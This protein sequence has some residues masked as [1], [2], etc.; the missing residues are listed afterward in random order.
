MDASHLA[1]VERENIM[2]DILYSSTFDEEVL[3]ALRAWQVAHQSGPGV[4]VPLQWLVE[5]GLRDLGYHAEG[6]FR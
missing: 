3:R 1:D 5:F 2:N 6:P 4:G